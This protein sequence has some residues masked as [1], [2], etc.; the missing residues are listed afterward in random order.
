MKHSVIILT[1]QTTLEYETSNLLLSFLNADISATVC[2]FDNFDIIIGQGM[3]YLGEDF[4]LPNLVLVRLGAGITPEQISVIRCFELNGVRCVNTSTS[5]DIV[6]N[7]FCTYQLLNSAN[8][9]VPNTMLV[10]FPADI[11]LIKNNI[12][13][14]CVVKVLVGSFGEGVYLIHSSDEYLKFV[15]FLEN[16]DNNKKLLVQEYISECPGEDLRIL[17]VGDKV[18]GA[19]K[20]TAPEGDFRANITIGGKGE[21]YPVTEEIEKI[22]LATAHVLG[23]EIAGIDLLFDKQGFRICEANSNPGF[24]GFDQ[25]CNANVA[26]EIVDYIKSIF[27]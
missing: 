25:Y 23:L 11:N 14:P 18:I 19:M 1:K 9:A 5:V 7:K 4:E 10:K 8:I 13:F 15:E 2:Q 20:R 6:Q 27:N 26:D 12:G 24:K 3:K 17:V 22:A 16:I 21:F